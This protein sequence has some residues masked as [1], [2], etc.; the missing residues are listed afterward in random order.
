MAVSQLTLYGS[1]ARE[2]NMNYTDDVNFSFI[3]EA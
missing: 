2:Q 3:S 1:R